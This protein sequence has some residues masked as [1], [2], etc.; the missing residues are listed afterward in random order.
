MSIDILNDM[1]RK[2]GKTTE[3]ISTES[4]IPK[5]TLNKL[6][7]GQTKDPQ[8]STIYAVVHSL[9]YTVSDLEPAKKKP[10]SAKADPSR[11][12]SPEEV[13][14]KLIAAGIVKE[15]E[16]LSDSDLAFFIAIGELIKA[17]FSSRDLELEPSYFLYNIYTIMNISHNIAIFYIQKN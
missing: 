4:G 6:F 16:D 1:K 2:S 13:Y 15:G 5:G 9:G 10:E 12:L 8:Y 7:A 3:Q 17:W 11:K 14:K